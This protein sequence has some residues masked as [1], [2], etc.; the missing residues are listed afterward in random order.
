MYRI[1][2]EKC[3]NPFVDGKFSSFDQQCHQRLRQNPTC[4]S[5]IIGDKDNSYSQ[6]WNFCV[7]LLSD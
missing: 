4:D 3:K 2:R 6:L 5:F 7:Y 1:S